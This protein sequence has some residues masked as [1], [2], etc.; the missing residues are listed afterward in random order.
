MAYLG[1]YDAVLQ[2]L[3]K[4]GVR[5][6]GLKRQ[7]AGSTGA[8]E[9]LGAR[10]LRRMRAM[11]DQFEFTRS[12]VQ[13]DFHEAFLR[14]TAQHLYS[15]D[16]VDL[17]TVMQENGWDDLKQYVLCLTP[18]RFGKTTAVALFVATYAL[19]VENS[20]ISIFSTGKRASTK[21]LELIATMVRQIPGAAE[22]IKKCNGEQLYLDR[23]GGGDIRKVNSYPSATTT[24]RGV[25][26]DLI[27][28]EEAAFMD[29]S[30]FQ[31]V[32]VPLLE[33]ETTS[34]LA[35]STPQ[36]ASNFYSEMFEMKKPNGELFFTQI[37]VGLSCAMCQKNGTPETCTHTAAVIPP[38]KSASKLDLV[39]S[40]YGDRKDLLLR[41]SMGQITEDVDCMYDA[42]EVDALVNT[43][44]ELPTPPTHIALACDPTGGGEQSEMTLLAA[45]FA[46]GKFV[47][48]SL[49][50]KVVR[51]HYELEAFVRAHVDR[52]HA[53]YPA[54]YVVFFVENNL[55]QEASHI[56]ATVR[57]YA[58]LH[59]VCEKG[60]VGVETTA[61]RKELY[62]YELKKYTATGAC[63]VVQPLLGAGSLKQLR[64]QLLAYKRVTRIGISGQASVHFSGKAN[65]ARDDL[66]VT[67]GLLAHWL[68]VFVARQAPVDYKV[69]DL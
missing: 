10:R 16:T 52:L 24:L 48:L 47:L 45:C 68:T 64:S 27:I 49:D 69:F 38:W 17:S 8:G 30:V 66:A 33:M 20:E 37:R 61:K 22:L 2:K 56:A 7:H 29:I 63:A 57:H 50:H 14:A 23:G 25:G 65:G 11:L 13:R 1:A 4:R 18:R 19:C 36:S 12:A 5:H 46:Q 32:V 31:Q 67:L 54:A 53:R 26:G 21:L 51:G 3:E 44:V 15:R 35:I 39:T 6:V 59:V 42:P 9:P 43:R 58:R 62:A 41:E 60:K 34:M 55:G 28:L 40:L